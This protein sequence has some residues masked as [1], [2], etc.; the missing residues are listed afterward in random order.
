MSNK[1]SALDDFYID[2]HAV[3]NILIPHK[4]FKLAVSRLCQS[5]ELA[6]RGLEPRHTLLI[7]ESGAGKSWLA[8]HVA[9]LFPR[10]LEQHENC[11]PV[12][13]VST[14]PNPTLKG[15]AETILITLGDPVSHRGTAVER[16]DRALVLLKKCE[17]EIV[18]F[19][20]LQH[21]LD[22]GK[23]NSLM[24][25]TDWLKRFIDE[26]RIPCVL[27]GLPRC[28]MILHANEQL[29]RRFSSRLELPAFSL[30]TEENELEF[31]G[32]LQSI[33]NALP[34]DG[35][36]NFSNIDLTER[37]Y[38]AS[39]GLLGYL[40]ALITG[41][42]ELMVAEN[43]RVIDIQLLEQAFIDVIWNE[44]R[45]SL[46]PFNPAFN[47][48]KLDRLGEPFGVT[49]SKVSSEPKSGRA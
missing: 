48:R 9:S 45:K 36:S 24:S 3:E 10:R 31:R 39:N 19:D 14:P 23:Y 4:H 27:M 49:I 29:R 8:E 6:R 5:I 18:V 28:D 41:A 15:L 22:H 25:V 42:F 46:N 21:F 1:V 2:L 26:S 44:G 11:K 35:R 43:K 33:D 13:V 34:T 30:D 38:F 40:R 16:L 37:L 17:V 32:V 47:K 12:L 7:G 20:E